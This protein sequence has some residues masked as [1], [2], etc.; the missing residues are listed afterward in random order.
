[1]ADKTP[2]SIAKQHEFDFLA[3]PGHCLIGHCRQHH[4][5]DGRGRLQ[6]DP[7]SD[8]DVWRAAR[9]CQ[10]QQPGRHLFPVSGGHSQLLPRRP[11][12]HA[13][14]AQPVAAHDFWGACRLRAGLRVAQ[15]HPEAHPAHQH[16]ERGCRQLFQAADDVGA[17]R[18]A[19][20]DDCLHPRRLV[21]AVS[22][23][24]I[25]RLC[26][27]WRGFCAAAH[28]QRLAAL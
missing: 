22:G 9:H 5:H 25:W 17:G 8:D 2:A 3:V 14:F 26:A 12:A 24:C 28:F 11:A 7:A 15:R 6:P 4:Q 10:R 27:G 18:C 1:M 20:Q 23:R 19:S 21:A 13:R 16:A